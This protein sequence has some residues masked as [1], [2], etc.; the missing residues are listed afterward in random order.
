MRGKMPHPIKVL[1]I[2]PGGARM[3][4]L[5]TIIAD[6]PAAARG[7]VGAVMGLKKLKAISVYGSKRPELADKMGFMALVLEQN[8]RLNANPATSDSLRFRGTV[9]ILLGVNA[10]GALPTRNYQDVQ[11]KGA[12]KI[13]G[14]A[15]QKVLWN[16]G[17]NWHPCWNCVIKCT[18]FH[19]LEQ[20]GYE[21]KIDDGPE[22]E[23][24]ALLGSACGIDD[25]KAIALADYLID[26]YGLDAIGLGNTIAFLMECYKKGLIVK[27]MT[28][29][30]DLKFGDREVWMAAIRAAGEG[31]GDLGRLAANGSLRAARI[32]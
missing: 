32:T 20:P 12:E 13:G 26:G 17:R 19:A 9:N 27:A 31:V 30:I 21:G 23:T 24:T 11:F 6:A 28:N 18:H 7:G 5:A 15:M 10:A 1:S 2:G 3:D 22:Y 14:E 16:D 8:K 25:P 4:R 29:G